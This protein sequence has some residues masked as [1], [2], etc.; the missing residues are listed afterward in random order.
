[1]YTLLAGIFFYD[2][3]TFEKLKGIP[4]ILKF[5]PRGR[6]EGHSLI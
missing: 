4:Q 5:Y 3:Y 6:E 2:R 1:M